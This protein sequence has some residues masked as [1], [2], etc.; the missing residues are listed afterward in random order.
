MLRTHAQSGFGEFL[1]LA[2]HRPKQKVHHRLRLFR[3]VEHRAKERNCGF[4][5][6]NSLAQHVYCFQQHL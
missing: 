2:E 4:Q 6:L 3:T 1:S 5:Q